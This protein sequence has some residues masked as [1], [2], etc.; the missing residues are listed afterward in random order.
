MNLPPAQQDKVSN[1]TWPENVWRLL[2][3]I[4]AAAHEQGTAGSPSHMPFN[5]LQ[6]LSERLKA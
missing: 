3:L 4:Q 5:T 2:L 6:N 1:I